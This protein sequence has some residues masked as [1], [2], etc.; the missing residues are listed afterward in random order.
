V[1]ATA[2]A[3]NEGAGDT[4][5]MLGS[6][7][8]LRS[9]RQA[10]VL[11]YTI[12]AQLSKNTWNVIINVFYRLVLKGDRRLNTWRGKRLRHAAWF[13]PDVTFAV[14]AWASARTA[15]DRP[16]RS[17]PLGG[18]ARRGSVR[19]G[20]AIKRRT[21]VDEARSDAELWA[22]LKVIGVM[23]PVD[24]STILNRTPPCQ[25]TCQPRRLALQLAAPRRS[26]P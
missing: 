6:S 1:C 26:G 19:L 22:N 7:R 2:L 21:S 25:Q 15:S 24:R 11:K 8:L 14:V 12:L 23:S 9:L 5:R 20:C 3:L 4:L 18:L 10:F 16:D 13:V 17:R